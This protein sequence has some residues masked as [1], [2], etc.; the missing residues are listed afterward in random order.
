MLLLCSH[1]LVSPFSAH[2][3]QHLSSHSAPMQHCLNTLSLSS[4]SELSPAYHILLSVSLTLQCQL[5]YCSCYSAPA[6]QLLISP[7]SRSLTL[8][9][10]LLTLLFPS[11]SL[12]FLPK[13]SE[14]FVLDLHHPCSFC[15][16]FSICSYLFSPCSSA[17][18]PVASQHSATPFLR[19]LQKLSFPLTL[20]VLASSLTFGISA[21]LSLFH[22]LSFPSALATSSEHLS[23]RSSEPSVLTLLQ[24]LNS[25]LTQP[26]LS[27][28]SSVLLL[29]I[30]SFSLTLQS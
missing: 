24:H 14:H 9:L 20:Q 10:I 5:P 1:S 25:N 13:V 15:L 3:L 16:F 17:Y 29:I 11:H 21:L 2:A 23:V 28:S 19:F 7:R 12:I 4:L 22:H 30:V 6:I 27:F 8:F 26:L 18:G